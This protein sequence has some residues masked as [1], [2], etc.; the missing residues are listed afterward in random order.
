M[1]MIQWFCVFMR[2]VKQKFF[3]FSTIKYVVVLKMTQ[4]VTPMNLVMTETL[5]F[6]NHDF[7]LYQ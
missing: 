4:F 5:F 3:F 1:I 6:L 7:I 2:Q